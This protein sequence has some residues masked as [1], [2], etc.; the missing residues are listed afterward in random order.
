MVLLSCSPAATITIA[1]MSKLK[2]L[3]GG[4]L[5]DAEWRNGGG[6]LQVG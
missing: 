1:K 3:G 2:A 6:V 5:S 4:T